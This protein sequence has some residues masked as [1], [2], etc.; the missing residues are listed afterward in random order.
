M[1]GKELRLENDNGHRMR[2]LVRKLESNPSDIKEVHFGTGAVTYECHKDCIRFTVEL[3]GAKTALIRVIMHELDEKPCPSDENVPYRVKA[4]LRR[5]LC[6][7]RDNY[8]TPTRFRL[9]R[10]R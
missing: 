8:V 10:S 2:Y 1:Y 3:N 6:E 5:Y 4:M 7:L 9:I